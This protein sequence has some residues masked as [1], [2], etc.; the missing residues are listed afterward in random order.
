M[1]VLV[2]LIAAVVAVIVVGLIYLQNSSLGNDTGGDDMSPVVDNA[3]PAADI[4]APAPIGPASPA[5]P[6]PATQSP[7]P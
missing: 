1:L 4:N 5:T 7:Q 2:A 3:P 6:S